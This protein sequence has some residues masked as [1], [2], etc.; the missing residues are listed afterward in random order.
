MS[1]VYSLENV[2]RLG[3]DFLRRPLAPEQASGG[4]RLKV[5]VDRDDE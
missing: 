4:A 1:V 2:E 3:R 5:R